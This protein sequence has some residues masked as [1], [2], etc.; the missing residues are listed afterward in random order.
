[1]RLDAPIFGSLNKQKQKSC[2][3]TYTVG[4]SRLASF[5]FPSYKN[6]FS[7][8]FIL[9]TKNR[10]YDINYVKDSRERGR[11][12][13]RWRDAVKGCLNDIGL[14][15]PEAKECVKDRRVGTIAGGRR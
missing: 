3:L 11:P 13:R 2:P 9:I 8:Y 1:M 5:T 6:A 15:I 10:F 14:T 12:R 7:R 4:V